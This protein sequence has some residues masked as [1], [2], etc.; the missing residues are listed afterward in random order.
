MNDTDS[1]ICF[2]DSDAKI[3]SG[4]YFSKILFMI[5]SLNN[6]SR[7]SCCNSFRSKT[8]IMFIPLNNNL[9]KFGCSLCQSLNFTDA[10]NIFILSFLDIYDSAISC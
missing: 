2:S 1:I 4:L 6:L 10:S 7:K 3:F 9:S 8:S 5:N